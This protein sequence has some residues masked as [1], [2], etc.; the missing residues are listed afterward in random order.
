MPYTDGTLVYGAALE[1]RVSASSRPLAD[2]HVIDE[3]A[4][5]RAVAAFVA[6]A[7]LLL[8]G[9]PPGSGSRHLGLTRSGIVHHKHFGLLPN[10]DVSS[11]TIAGH[12]LDDPLR[13]PSTL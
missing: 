11:F 7:A 10:Y 6:F 1:R 8:Q 5:R 3:D 12:R 2:F 4:V 9:P 13:V